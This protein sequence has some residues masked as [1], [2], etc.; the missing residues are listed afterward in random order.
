V[1][2]SRDFDLWVVPSGGIDPGESAEVAAEREVYEEVWLQVEKSLTLPYVQVGN[3][4]FSIKVDQ[5][6]IIQNL[7]SN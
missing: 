3:R 4:N 1:T 7:F 5:R 2:S 6:H